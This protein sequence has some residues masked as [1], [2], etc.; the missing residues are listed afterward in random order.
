MSMT[1]CAVLSCSEIASEEIENEKSGSEF[2][3][4]PDHKAAVENGHPWWPDR[5]TNG[6]RM[7]RDLPPGLAK[8]TVLETEA[9]GLILTIET[10]RPD[11]EPFQIYLSKDSYEHL[12]GAFRPV[13]KPAAQ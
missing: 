4:C 5:D 13:F 7:G 1:T 12:A 8:W 6:I 11:V 9:P 10:D 2:L 3:V